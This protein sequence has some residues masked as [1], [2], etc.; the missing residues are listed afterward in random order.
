VVQPEGGRGSGSEGQGASGSTQSR[1][2]PL[3]ELPAARCGDAGRRCRWSQ[4]SRRVDPTSATQHARLPRQ[5]RST[6]CTAAHTPAPQRSTQAC[7]AA[8]TALTVCYRSDCMLL[9]GPSPVISSSTCASRCCV[10]LRCR[11]R[12]Q[13][14]GCVCSHVS[15]RRPVASNRPAPKLEMPTGKCPSKLPVRLPASL[16]PSQHLLARPP[17]RC[18]PDHY[19]SSAA[20]KQTSTLAL[21]RSLP[22]CVNSELSRSLTPPALPRTCSIHIAPVSGASMC[23]RLISSSRI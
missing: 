17:G 7:L 16:P 12:A 5:H 14:T 19:P 2:T 9:C 22:H 21:T 18:L 20:G 13:V 4:Q 6:A 10:R 8:G 3:A 11:K 23:R 1:E 15:R